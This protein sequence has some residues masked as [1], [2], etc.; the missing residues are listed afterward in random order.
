[1]GRRPTRAAMKIVEAHIYRHER[2]VCHPEPP[3]RG[4]GRVE[5]SR[6]ANFPAA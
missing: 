4:G 6:A 5:G 3:D 1:M 2:P